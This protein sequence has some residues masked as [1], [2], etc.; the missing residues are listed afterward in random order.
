MR[1]DSPRSS[2]R[3]DLQPGIE[4][5]QF[6]QAAGKPLELEL[7]RDREDRRVGQER[8][9]RAGLFGILQGADDGELLRGDAALERHVVDLAVAE[10][11]G[12]EPIGKRVDA[13]RAHAV[14]AAGIFVRP[15]AEFAARVQVGQ[16]QFDGRDAELRVHVHGD[17]AAVVADGAGAIDVDGHVD[18]RART[19]Q[20]LVD[21]VIQHLENAVV[22]TPFVRRPDVHA[23]PLADTRQ[24]FELVD[25]GGVILL[26]WIEVE[27][28]F[29]GNRRILHDRG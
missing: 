23:R 18:L 16:H 11:L 14:Q 29:G 13:L 5:R 15:L 26:I 1:T 25:L 7:R 4:K 24:P 6:A 20:M 19:G 8:D 27:V 17:A 21:G 3:I 12:L 10:H 9:E 22:Q 2:V 28:R